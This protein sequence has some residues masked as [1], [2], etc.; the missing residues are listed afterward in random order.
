MATA[1]II[2]DAPTVRTILARMVRSAGVD[3]LEAG[4]QESA[5]RI[6]DEYKPDVLFLDL[7]LGETSGLDVLRDIR[8]RGHTMPV[9]VVS[10][11]RGVHVV[12]EVLEAGVVD[13]VAKPFL[14]ERVMQAIKKA[15]PEL[16]FLAS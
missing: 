16:S 12:R 2:D 8:E 9:V 3:T 5:V 10:A 7:N 13:F 14:R 11:E 15:V 4:D 6:C 1:L